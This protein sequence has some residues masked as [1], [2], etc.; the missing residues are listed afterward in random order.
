MEESPELLALVNAIAVEHWG[1]AELTLDEVE[2]WFTQD[3]VVGIVAERD[4]VLVGYGDRWCGGERNRAQ[5]D[6]HVHPGD[7]EAAELLLHELETL[8]RPDVDPGSPASIMVA[9][10]RDSVGDVVAAAG[11]GLVRQA[12]RMGITLNGLEP[13]AVPPGI[14]IRTYEPADEAEVYATHQ[15]TFSDLVDHA[16][17]GPEEW[18]AFRIETPSFDPTLWFVARDADRVAGIALC[19]V[20]W[21]GNPRHGHVNILGVRR[22]WRGRGLGIALLGHAFTSMQARGMTKATLGV[23]SDNATGA[24]RL[25]ER[26][27]MS[28]ERSYDIYRKELR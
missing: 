26:A 22:P 9:G 19:Q 21:S 23:D 18:R 17:V 12:L 13:A 28:V 20:H 11:Y 24:V 2:S 7:V 1:A 5:L 15:E 27:G 6:I 16:R 8:A 4:R 25:Y 10:S 3:G 14:E